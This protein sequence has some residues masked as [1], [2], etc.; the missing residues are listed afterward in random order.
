MDMSLGREDPEATGD[1]GSK[2]LLRRDLRLRL[3]P[4][5][6]RNSYRPG[7][8]SVLPYR[9]PDPEGHDCQVGQR[10]GSTTPESLEQGYG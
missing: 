9:T 3:D 1:I 7:S 4:P 10:E 2:G 6:G 5:V 8:V